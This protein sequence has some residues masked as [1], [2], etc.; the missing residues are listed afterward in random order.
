MAQEAL[1]VFISYAHGDEG[2]RRELEK[3]L[4]ALERR[5]EIRAW[6]VGKA[7]AGE[8]RQ[9]Q[10]DERLDAA[11]LILLLVSA[12]YLRSDECDRQARRALER[13]GQARV[14][15]IIV[16]PCLWEEAPFGKFE[17]LPA[18]GTPITK[19]PN[20]DEAWTDVARGIQ[21]AL[22][23]ATGERR[24]TTPPGRRLRARA[25][26]VAAACLVIL[27]AVGLSDLIL[28]AL[29]RLWGAI[30]FPAPPVFPQ[31]LLL[32]LTAVVLAACLRRSQASTGLL[33]LNG[34]LAA[35]ALAIFYGWLHELVSP[36]P[37]HIYGRVVTGDTRDVKVRVVD[38]FGTRISMGEVPIDTETGRFGIRL[39][40]AFGGR[41]RA[42]VLTSNGCRD[43]FHPVKRTDWHEERDV[44][45][46]FL[47]AEGDRS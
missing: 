42:V 28:D 12:S 34:L 18:D 2:P 15:P 11:N 40:L 33:A 8:E 26:P 39:R 3:H 22:G 9:D 36:P 38:D 14:I 16:A 30:G 47:C 19:W 7:V 13:R 31:A 5:G 24:R 45:V 46:R 23:G 27:T 35:L 32:G 10:V 1:D 4:A 20:V 17:V 25:L 43:S 21:K 44:T 37:D 6:H 41:P 29:S